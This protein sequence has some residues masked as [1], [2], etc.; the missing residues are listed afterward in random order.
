MK[1]AFF[2]FAAS[3]GVVLG[4]L[5]LTL[6]QP[7]EFP[8]LAPGENASA[9]IQLNA[10][11]TLPLVFSLDT[12]SGSSLRFTVTIMKTAD[13]PLFTLESDAAQCVYLPPGS[14]VGTTGLCDIQISNV[15]TAEDAYWFAVS[16]QR[17]ATD[18][19]P[20]WTIL[21]TA[22]RT[23]LGGTLYVAED[24]QTTTGSFVVKSEGSFHIS[25][26]QPT[27]PWGPSNSAVL[28]IGASPDE[29]Y[30]FPADGFV[31]RGGVWYMTVTMSGP[32]TCAWLQP[33]GE[34]GSCRC[35]DGVVVDYSQNCCGEYGGIAQC[36]RDLPQMC[37]ASVQCGGMHCCSSDCAAEFLT[38]PR[39]CFAAYAIELLSDP[40]SQ[41]AHGGGGL[42]GGAVFLILFFSSIAAYCGCGMVFQWMNGARAC[43][44]IMPHHNFWVEVPVFMKEGW[45]WLCLRL[46]GVGKQPNYVV[47]SG[48][49]AP[50]P[51]D[52]MG[53]ANE[54]ESGLVNDNTRNTDYGTSNL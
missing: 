37:A 1:A 28:A 14:L 48:D 49:Y 39:P 17:F 34:D 23:S 15:G 53:E 25:V 54:Q 29:L 10:S 4:R 52:T 22:E 18:D 36:P 5:D 43:P 35:E 33:T 31:V 11:R 2:V 32:A 24:G 42:S 38:L 26:T 41:D 16:E 9:E 44:E 6:G 40:S 3:V 21:D 30:E 12:H 46:C 27:F 45:E 8:R 7:Q 47:Y 51:R 20:A 13:E 50:A 19:E